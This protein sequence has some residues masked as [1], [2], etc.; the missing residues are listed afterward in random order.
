MAT[1]TEEAH[2]TKHFKDILVW[3]AKVLYYLVGVFVDIHCRVARA[4]TTDRRIFSLIMMIAEKIV[5]FL[6]T[7]DNCKL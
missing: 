4:Q 7:E 2:K 5:Y 6:A 1:I 3:G